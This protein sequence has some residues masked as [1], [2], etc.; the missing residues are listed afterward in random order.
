L[1]WLFAYDLYLSMILFGSL[2][3]GRVGEPL[4]ALR[5]R[6]HPRISARSF[7]GFMIFDHAVDLA[8]II[9]YFA[10]AGLLVLPAARVNLALRLTWVAL[11]VALAVLGAWAAWGG[12][13]RWKP[14]LAADLSQSTRLLLQRPGTLAVYLLLTLIGLLGEPV[15]YMLA[16]RS[17][18]LAVG[19]IQCI[20]LVEAGMLS[21]VVSL[22]P[23]G[24]G[25]GEWTMT[26]IAA[27]F[28]VNGQSAAALFVVSR[29][30]VLLEIAMLTALV[31]VAR[32]LIR[33]RSTNG[34]DGKNGWNDGR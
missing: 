14:D 15:F 2:T 32:R 23:G 29:F 25:V 30:V 10:A 9:A 3:P 31:G 21:G 19:P 20:F 18:A 7:F 28:G 13:K 17:Q 11:I 24:L 34:R 8:V 33:A 1:P 26:G 12:L 27:G 4:V 22:I 5:L 6:G 16:F